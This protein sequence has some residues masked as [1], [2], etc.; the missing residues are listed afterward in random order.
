LFPLSQRG[1]TLAE[2]VELAGQ[3]DLDAQG[4]GISAISELAN[5]R[6][7]ALLH[8]NGNHF[9]VLESVKNGKFTVQDP[10]F[11]TRIYSAIDMEIYFSGI[12][13]EFEPRV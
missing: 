13:L 9:V 1:M 4:L 12:A 10:A 6:C 3:L 5:L 11:G 7:P 8:W 2:I